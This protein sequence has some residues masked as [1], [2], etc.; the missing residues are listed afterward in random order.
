M[1]YEVKKEDILL[2][3]GIIAEKG[4]LIK[5]YHICN[6]ISLIRLTKKESNVKTIHWINI[7]VI[8][9]NKKLLKLIND[10]HIPLRRK[11]KRD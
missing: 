9:N 1:V 11:L 8:D 4:D 2:E 5:I 6:K 3:N 10:D 7:E